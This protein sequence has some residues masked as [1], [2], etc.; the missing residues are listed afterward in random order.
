MNE[1]DEDIT[2]I[3]LTDLRTTWRTLMMVAG[4]Y[5]AGSK[6]EASLIE[7]RRLVEMEIRAQHGDAAWGALRV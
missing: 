6:G 2:S 7:A 1:T 4:N 3:A 5:S